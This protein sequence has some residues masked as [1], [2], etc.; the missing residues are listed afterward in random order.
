MNWSLL[1]ILNFLAIESTIEVPHFQKLHGWKIKM[2][3]KFIFSSFSKDLLARSRN[4]GKLAGHSYT[5]FLSGNRCIFDLLFSPLPSAILKFSPWF[6]SLIPKLF[7]LSL[8]NCVLPYVSNFL[9]FFAKVSF[10]VLEAYFV[11]IPLRAT[12][13]ILRVWPDCNTC[14]FQQEQST[15][16]K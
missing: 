14:L 15:I 6:H 11:K 2:L 13:T 5:T 16:E 1:C 12:K 10:F 3:A 9:M 7:L 4:F 8:I